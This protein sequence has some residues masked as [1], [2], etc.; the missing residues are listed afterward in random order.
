MDKAGVATG[1]T[2]EIG[3]KHGDTVTLTAGGAEMPTW[4]ANADPSSLTRA[5]TGYQSAS[6]GGISVVDADVDAVSTARAGLGSPDRLESVGRWIAVALA[7]TAA[8]NSRVANADTAARMNELVHCQMVQ[9]AAMS[10]LAQANQVPFIVLE[11]LRRQ[12]SH[13]E[14]PRATVDTGDGRWA[15]EL[16]R[17]RSNQNRAVAVT[18]TDEMSA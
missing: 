14:V 12:V 17:R 16:T 6:C 4:N 7:N 2:P 8:A 9:Q 5:T 11:L 18:A 15:S 10:E 3:A 13:R 1:M